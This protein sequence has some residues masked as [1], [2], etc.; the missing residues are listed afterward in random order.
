MGRLVRPV[1]P[2]KPLIMN[3]HNISNEIERSPRDRFYDMP[4]DDS[5]KEI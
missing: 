4:V 2:V 5:L 3:P 1:D